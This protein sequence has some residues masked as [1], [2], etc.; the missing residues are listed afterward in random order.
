[1]EDTH[2]RLRLTIFGVAVF[3]LGAVCAYGTFW[4]GARL[5]DSV[6]TIT[7]V[8]SQTHA[9][10]TLEYGEQPLLRQPDFFKQ[11]KLLISYCFISFPFVFL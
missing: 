2:S 9:K 4:Y 3:M 10:T 11:V 8:D 5:P 1:M 6:P 7:L